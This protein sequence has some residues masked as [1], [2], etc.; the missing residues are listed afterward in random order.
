MRGSLEECIVHYNN[1]LQKRCPKGS[2]GTAKAR[3]K[4]I[5]FCKVTDK[6]AW[7]WLERK[8]S[9]CGENIIMVTA[10]LQ[11]Q[12]YE[13]IDVERLPIV[14]RNFRELIG[15]HVLSLDDAKDALGYSLK[16]SLLA[17]LLG[18]QGISDQKKE[19]MRD[20]WKSNRERLERKKEESLLTFRDYE[21]EGNVDETNSLSSTENPEKDAGHESVVSIMQGLLGL[22]ETDPFKKAIEQNKLTEEDAGI[23]LKLSLRL[24][25]ISSALMGIGEKKKP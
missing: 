4:M 25:G 2:K 9:P 16:D 20:I 10:F 1:A 7:L 21:G 13:I 3:S 23:I 11:C 8:T 18:T 22:I 14:I 12:G 17:I 15:Y 5:S 6:S 19:R 24:A